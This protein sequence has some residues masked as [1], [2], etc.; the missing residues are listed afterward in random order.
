MKVLAVDLEKCNGA[1]AC[2]AACATTLFKTADAALSAVQV[3]KT[4]G[5]SEARVCD[6][7][8][9]C[10]PVCPTLALYR[11][12]AGTVLLK[13]ELCVGCFMCVGFCSKGA[14]VRARERL[15]PIKCISCGNCVEACPSGALKLVEKDH[16]GLPA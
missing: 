13:K 2:M 1:Q 14:M 6:Q 8:G 10:I 3:T 4:S 7:C 11:G 9:D 12:K 15:E 5:P 16:Q